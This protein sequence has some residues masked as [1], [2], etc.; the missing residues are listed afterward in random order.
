MPKL[1]RSLSAKIGPLLSSDLFENRCHDKRRHEQ[2]QEATQIC[3]E[4]ITSLK[5]GDRYP[6]LAD[7]EAETWSLDR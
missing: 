1:G 5:T 7:T 4:A 2:Y 3:W 6:W